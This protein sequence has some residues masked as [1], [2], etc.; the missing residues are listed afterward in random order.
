MKK[1]LAIDL[2][3]TTGWATNIPTPGDPRRYVIRAGVVNFSPRSYESSGMRY[4]RFMQWVAETVKGKDEV[5]Y[6]RV[7]RHASNGAA[8]I[9]GGFMACLT[10]FCE[11]HG[12]RYIEV[13]VSTIKRHWTGSGNAKKEMMIEQCVARGFQPQDDNDADAYAL[14]DFALDQQGINNA[15]K[16]L[17]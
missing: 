12:V 2:G 3:T 5:Y 16:I 14:L 15:Q 8:Q 7:I 13:N 1:I 10:A 17:G 11:A 4:Y 6:E 9:Y